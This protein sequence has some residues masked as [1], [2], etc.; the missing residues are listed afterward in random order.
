M[1]MYYLSTLTSLPF[2]AI[3]V[4]LFCL[5]ST[6]CFSILAVAHTGVDVI[7]QVS[8]EFLIENNIKKGDS[9]PISDWNTFASLLEKCAALGYEPEIRTG[10]SASNT[11]KGLA[12]LGHSCTL[13]GMT[14]NDAAADF[15]RNNL[16]H[17]GVNTILIPSKLPSSQFATFVTKDLQRTFCV[18]FGAG[19]S[20]RAEDIYPELFKG[21]SFVHLEGYLFDDVGLIDRTAELAKEQSATISMDIGAIRIAKT[22]GQD[23]L[24]LANRYATIVFSNE[25]EIHT[26]FN[27]TPEEGCL[28]LAKLCPIAIVQVGKKGCV[29]ASKNKLFKS[30]AIDAVAIDTTGAGDLFAAGFIHGY[31][32][33]YDLEECAWIGNLLGGTAVTVIG[34]EIPSDRWPDLSQKIINHCSY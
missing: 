4:T 3:I 31:I 26:L 15:Y 18:Y 27:L 17:N 13:F 22:Y 16:N 5:F 32:N 14:S 10:G 29:V 6:S 33:H 20:I 8:D 23:F 28:E 30:P 19:H 11:I 21:H 24:K 9:N 12:A 34:A 25:E 2:L 1:D 7:Y